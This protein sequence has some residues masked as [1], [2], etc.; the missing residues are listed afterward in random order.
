MEEIELG[1]G[2]KVETCKEL[3]ESHGHKPRGNRNSHR[4]PNEKE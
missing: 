4:P 3:E 2:D 1:E